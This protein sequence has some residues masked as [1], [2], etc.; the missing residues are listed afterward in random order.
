MAEVITALKMV[1]R[2]VLQK[3]RVNSRKKIGG[4]ILLRLQFL[5]LRANYEVYTNVLF[6]T[7]LANC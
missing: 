1:R 4:D 5:D 7:I 2:F 3:K 6:I